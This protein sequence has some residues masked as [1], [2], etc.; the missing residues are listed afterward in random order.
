MAWLGIGIK[1]A[2]TSNGILASGT[3]SQ[4]GIGAF[5]Y[6]TGSPYSRLQE[7]VH[8]VQ[9]SS[10]TCLRYRQV[11]H[12]FQH[13]RGLNYT[14]T[15]LESGQLE[16]VL[17]WTCLYTIGAYTAPE[18][19]YT[20]ESCGHLDMSTPQ[21]PELHLDVS[22]QKESMLVWTCLHHRGLSCT[23]MFLHHRVLW[24]LGHVHLGTPTSTLQGLC[25]TW[26]CTLHRGLR[27][28]WQVQCPHY[29]VAC[30]YNSGT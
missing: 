8:C 26:T 5:W 12:M 4:S 21:G 6:R 30:V 11:L 10:W 15:S 3:V 14:W 24:T 19:F 1:A 20:T 23:W 16:S 29:H 18:C 13:H 25:C 2:T 28:P 27:R 7:T 9:W 22:G 17:V